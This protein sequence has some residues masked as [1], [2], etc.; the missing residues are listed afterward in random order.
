[1][2]FL[3]NLYL[4]ENKKEKIIGN[5]LLQAIRKH[6]TTRYTPEIIESISFYKKINDYTESHPAFAKSLQRLH[7]KMQRKGNMLIKIFY[8]H[9]LAS[10]WD[11][12]SSLPLATYISDAYKAI[13][14]NQKVLPYKINHTLPELLASPYLRQIHTFGGLHPY[15]KDLTRLV[16]V[17]TINESALN[18]LMQHYP[19]FKND[20]NEYF[21]DLLSITKTEE[22][23]RVYQRIVA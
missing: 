2:N 3:I 5:F 10:A 16:K 1:M 6:D 11:E 4:S 14:E 7:P 21:A 8:D 9:F 22:N 12:Y 23:S 13:V 17:N 20:F 18:D 19:E 15:L